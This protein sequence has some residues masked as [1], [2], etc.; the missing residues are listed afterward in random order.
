MFIYK[1]EYW[2]EYEFGDTVGIWDKN[3]FTDA[4]RAADETARRYP[5]ST[6]AVT[7]YELNVKNGFREVAYKTG[8]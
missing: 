1:V 7:K 5:D 2:W 6:V 8:G 4:K 3:H